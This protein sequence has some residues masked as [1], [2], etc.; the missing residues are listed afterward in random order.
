[1]ICLDR[2]GLASRPL[3][4]MPNMG[5]IMPVLGAKTSSN[6]SRRKSLAD[7]L[8]TKTQQRVLRGTFR[9]A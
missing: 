7:A 5:M 6:R 4:R 2:L 1:M 9:A 8:F 3:T